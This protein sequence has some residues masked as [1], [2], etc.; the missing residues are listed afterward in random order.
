MKRSLLIV[1]AALA[2]TIVACTKD[3]GTT[4]IVNTTTLSKHWFVRVQGPSSTSNYTL[5]STRSL[6]IVEVVDTFGTQ[7]SRLLTDTMTLD[8]HNFL[9]PTLR[10]NVRIDA[11]SRT[12]GAGQY[13][14]WNNTSDSLIVKEGKMIKS[15]GRSR[16]GNVVDSIYIRYAFK[17][18]PTVEYQLKGHERTGLLADEY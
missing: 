16:S 5:F 11:P 3:N 15:G 13:K 17:S 2:V 12:F 18:A 10:A 1:V 7:Q 8:D 9:N 14:N 6:N 4:E